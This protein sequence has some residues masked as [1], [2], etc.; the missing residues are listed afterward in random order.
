M[1]GPFQERDVLEVVVAEAK[2]DWYV[3]QRVAEFRLLIAY[4]AVATSTTTTPTT[5]NNLNPPKSEILH[6]TGIGIEGGEATN[7][8]LQVQIR[9]PAAVIIFGT[10][11]SP[12]GGYLTT[13]LSPRDSPYP[14]NQF[15]LYERQPAILFVNNSALFSVT[16]KISWEG[17]RYLVRPLQGDPNTP[18][19]EVHKYLFNKVVE[20]R[21]M[22]DANGAPVIDPPT[23]RQRLEEVTRYVP[24]NRPYSSVSVAG[25]R[26]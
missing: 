8:E 1:K 9:N 2:S 22:I 10:T 24:S 7:H 12:T 23:G 11:K 5:E 15:I 20:R 3:I 13:E 17:Y 26:S 14:L 18:D 25:F 21:N 4:S 6:L 16:P 19:S